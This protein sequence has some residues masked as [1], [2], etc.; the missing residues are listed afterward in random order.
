MRE[1]CVLRH[2]SFKTGKTYV[3]W[4]RRYSEFLKDQPVASWTTGPEA[5]VRSEGK[6]KT[7]TGRTP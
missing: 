6:N 3:Y 2:L 5:G 1:T 4:L 7:A